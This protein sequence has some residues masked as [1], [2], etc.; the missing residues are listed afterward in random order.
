MLLALAA[1][2]LLLAI[3]HIADDRSIREGALPVLDDH[4]DL[5][6]RA[7]LTVAHVSIAGLFVWALVSRTEVAGVWVRRVTKLSALT[8]F[9]AL[10]LLTWDLHSEAWHLIEPP[11]IIDGA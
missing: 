8:L 5:H 9:A 4:L 2:A 3:P 7:L 1:S 11:I 10:G 6:L